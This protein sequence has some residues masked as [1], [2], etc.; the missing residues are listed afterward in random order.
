M[1]QQ[2]PN[3]SDGRSPDDD[4][5]I[6]SEPFDGDDSTHKTGEH[7][8]PSVDPQRV[9]EADRV[10]DYRIV[11]VI[12]VGGMGIV[13]RA[14][15]VMLKRTVALKVM[16]PEVASNET[17]RK[18]FLREAESAA[19]IDHENIVT[20]YQV[21]QHKVGQH[22][23]GRH[24]GVPYIA[25]RYLSG[26]SLRER[27]KREGRIE[28]RLVANIGRQVATG[29]AA[30]HGIGLIHRDIKPDNLWLEAET[31]RVKILDFGLARSQETDMRLTKSG[32]VL[33][34]P[35]YMSPEQATA[36]TVDHRSDLFS[37]GSV[38]Y[39]LLSG[40]EPFG[41][42]DSAATLIKVTQADFAPIQKVCPNLN[43]KL[44]RLVNALLAKHPDKRPQ[45][46][47]EVA[48]NLAEI[49]KQLE[50]EHEANARRQ[51]LTETADL[52]SPDPSPVPTSAIPTG[53]GRPSPLSLVLLGLGIV[54]IGL[55][56]VAFLF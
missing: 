53:V 48:L 26:E 35:K 24:Q 20:I 33:G 12:G 51:S 15:D 16:K 27:L 43:P 41:G 34:T 11:D 23:V 10:G 39:H 31:G 29:L 47:R 38:L 46:A 18:R 50:A 37:L 54:L 25:M 17:F 1:T 45:S 9:L 55:L 5:T 30:A 3:Q 19:R 28:P 56:L 42:S 2:G 36:K 8:G 40:T 7:A 13:Y 32:V 49:E 4:E 44:A 22:K 14:E 21:G 6:V 52:A